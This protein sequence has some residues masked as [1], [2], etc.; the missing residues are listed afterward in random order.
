MLTK[1]ID[2]ARV[3]YKNKD[4][5]HLKHIHDHHG[6]EEHSSTGASIRSIVYGGLDG[7]ITTFAIVSGVAGAQLNAGIVLILGFANLIA[8]GISL[9]VGDYLSTK[10]EQEYQKK[11]REREEWELTQYPKGEKNEMIEIY[12]KKGYSKADANKIIT[13]LMKNKKSFVDTMMADELG[14]AE[15]NENPIKNGATTFGSFVVFGFVPLFAFVGAKLF[16]WFSTNTFLVSIILT[17]IT[18]FTLGALKVRVTGRDW[19]KSGLEMLLVGG[20]AAGAAYGIGVL[21]GGLA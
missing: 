18:M 15:N 17:G 20:V 12:T 6:V 2:K 11:E 16:G 5:Q 8:D 3:A 21:L 1:K 19:L 13:L 9:A 14:I 7:I 10:A 4:V